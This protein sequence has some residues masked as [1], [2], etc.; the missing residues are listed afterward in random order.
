[1]SEQEN[2]HEELEA[3]REELREGIESTIF[4]LASGQDEGP[5]DIDPLSLGIGE[6]TLPELSPEEQA[7]V[8]NELYRLLKI[9]EEEKQVTDSYTASDDENILVSVFKG[10]ERNDEGEEQV[11]YLH[12]IKHPDGELD[13][14]LSNSSD[15]LL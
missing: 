8:K 10:Q 7:I 12:E 6:Q 15:P 2:S 14:Q 13:W 3:F 9:N 1:M 4:I 11:F 5:F